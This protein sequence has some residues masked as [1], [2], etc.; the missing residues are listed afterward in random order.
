MSRKRIAILI[1]VI[2]AV[3][4]AVTAVIVFR[5]QIAAFIEFLEEKFRNP[6]GKSVPRENFTDEERE[7][8]ADI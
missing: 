6:S 7:S 4:A 1:S 5:R 2:A 8:F 3:A